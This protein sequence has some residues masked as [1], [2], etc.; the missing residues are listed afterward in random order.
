[1]EENNPRAVLFQVHLLADHLRKLPGTA[2]AHE[3]LSVGE[4]Q[5]IRLSASLRLA[6]VYRLANGPP[7]ELD[8]L[9]AETQED[10]E[11]ISDEITQ[12][13]FNHALETRVSGAGPR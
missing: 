11:A 9:L 3:R 6:D 4:R 8:H 7:D 5:L 1:M 12:H 13:F 2:Q 10:L